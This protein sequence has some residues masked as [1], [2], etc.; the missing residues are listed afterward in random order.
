M[1]HTTATQYLEAPWTESVQ[2]AVLAAGGGTNVD[3]NHQIE[4]QRAIQDERERAQEKVNLLVQEKERLEAEIQETAN[5][6]A[7][8]ENHEQ[9][10]ELCQHEEA[11]KEELE[12]IN[13]QI[14]RETMDAD[15][16]EY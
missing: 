5:S 16:G 11:L 1:D 10:D 4:H 9:L 15:N 14:E 7:E 12:L 8:P 13:A 3:E 6:I 2:N